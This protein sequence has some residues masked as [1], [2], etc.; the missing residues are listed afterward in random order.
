[1]TEFLWAVKSKQNKYTFPLDVFVF[2]SA[3]SSSS[4]RSFSEPSHTTSSIKQDVDHTRSKDSMIPTPTTPTNGD[5]RTFSA[6]DFVNEYRSR[7]DSLDTLLE[8]L[9]EFKEFLKEETISIIHKEYSS[10][11]EFSRKLNTITIDQM[12]SSMPTLIHQMK[13]FENFIYNLISKCEKELHSKKRASQKEFISKKL[14]E[15]FTLLKS[16]LIPKLQLEAE[17]QS[18]A[19]HEF[20]EDDLIFSSMADH[21]K[22]CSESMKQIE[23]ILLELSEEN[24]SENILEKQHMAALFEFYEKVDV[25]LKQT[26]QLF[27]DQV[28]STFIFFIKI[29]SKTL[30]RSN[31]NISLLKILDC[32]EG[33]Y[34]FNNKRL[35]EQCLEQE[36]INPLLDT[37]AS[38]ENLLQCKNNPEQHVKVLLYDN[39]LQ[40]VGN[41]IDPLLDILF[42]LERKSN[43]E[44]LIQTGYTDAGI[45]TGPY[46][47][48]IVTSFKFITASVFQP[49]SNRL[50]SDPCKFLYEYRNV[51]T[52]HFMF[53]GQKRFINEFKQKFVP[54]HETNT[55]T[56]AVKT[57]L[58]KKWQTKIYFAL[59]K[60]QVVKDFESIISQKATS[61]SKDNINSESIF[62][63]ITDKLVDLILNTIFNPDTTFLDE[64]SEDF[65][66]LFIQLISRYRKWLLEQLIP[67]MIQTSKNTTQE[68]ELL[69]RLCTLAKR[70]VG[71]VDRLSGSIRMD[72]FSSTRTPQ[73]KELLYNSLSERIGITEETEKFSPVFSS[74]IENIVNILKDKSIQIIASRLTQSYNFTTVTGANNSASP[75]TQEIF[76]KLIQFQ[77]QDFAK[78]N[79]VFLKR[80]LHQV[81]YDTCNQYKIECMK[82]VESNKKTQQSIDRFSKNKVNKVASIIDQI[83]R[84]CNKLEEIIKDQLFLDVKEPMEPLEQLRSTL[85]NSE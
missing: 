2:G 48:K 32:M 50:Q 51:K 37:I 57:L 28:C 31:Y 39:I 73:I 56:T 14:L 8:E 22:Q 30:A 54:K 58:L 27:L 72:I 24:I 66:L 18:V 59:V 46:I 47:R 79:K 42:S 60:Q 64:M 75:F 38:K 68:D 81:V 17:K 11:I 74:L 43:I 63:A 83:I 10:F 25:A 33:C 15:I 4:E 45:D 41:A 26:E 5:S 35:L 9:Q 65:I 84:D 62:T 67:S 7:V 3:P 1:M 49:I 71:V 19:N 12:N 80:I 69:S 78:T 82:I 36:L 85:N 61:S 6:I 34:L 13:E 55:F 53:Q 40:Q 20:S 76:K 52:F 29:N 21:V 44:E 23:V 16:N 70:L 77:N